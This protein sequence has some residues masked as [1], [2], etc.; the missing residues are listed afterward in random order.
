MHAK[1]SA[2]PR[3]SRAQLR[4][5]V[6]PPP[7]SR[8]TT[9]PTL[10]AL[11]LPLLALAL[12]AGATGQG[13][14]EDGS[15]PG[16]RAGSGAGTDGDAA[17]APMGARG[18]APGDAATAPWP[19]PEQERFR[20]AVR[21]GPIRA[22]EGTIE[23]APAAAGAPGAYLVSLSVEFGI[24]F[25]EVR[26][27]QR[28]WISPDPLQT[29]R[30]EKVLQE[31]G[32]ET[33][34]SWSLDHEEG[35]VRPEGQGAG[36]EMPESALDG[37]GMLYLLRTLEL[38]EGREFLLHRHFQPD[39]NPVRFRVVGRERIRVPAGRFRTVVVEPVIPALGVFREDRNARLWVTD[40]A[41]RLI[42]QMESATKLGPLRMH[43]RDFEVAD[44]G[45][46]DAPGSR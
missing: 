6:A 28:S 10:L 41:R 29:H 3:P 24:P 2:R 5:S 11:A 34:R 40:D 22:G 44:V 30:V 37:L 32:D 17:R 42:V 18:D 25:F 7:P 35:V 31:G 21:V 23:S 39:G 38:E 9:L 27:R 43:L 13:A 12:P 14:A 8:T 20:Y 46:G 26:D 33:R 4:H 15:R 45:E 36:T 1:P 19:F 16:T